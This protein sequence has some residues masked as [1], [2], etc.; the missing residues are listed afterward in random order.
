VRAAAFGVQPDFMD[1]WNHPQRANPDTV[2]ALEALLGPA[3]A[4][5]SEA[6]RGPVATCHLPEQERLW[7]WAAQLYAVRSRRSWGS[8]DLDDLARLAR[9]S[10][11][12]GAG[13]IQLNPL[14]AAAPVG[15]Q[16]ASPYFPSS[17]LFR[18]PAYIS[19]PHVR[20]YRAAAP[21]LTAELAEAAH[22]N[23]RGLIDHDR[24]HQVKLRALER[25]WAAG[26]PLRGFDAWAR[27]CGPGLWTYADYCVLA[28]RHGADWRTWPPPLRRPNPD[29]LRDPARARF[30]AWVQWLLDL[31]LGRAAQQ[32]RPICDLAIGA[33]P[34]GAD[35]WIWADQFLPGFTVGAPPDELNRDGQNWG[36]P[37]FS[38]SKLL[39]GGFGPFREIVRA[40]LRHA[41]GLRIDHVM[42]LF[43]LWLIP[44]GGGAGDGAYVTYPAAPML[45]II[46]SESRAAQALVI[47][48]DLG[49]VQPAVRRE[50]QRRHVLSY[51]LMF[52]EDGPPG[53]YSALS[54]AAVG[55]H[56]LPTIAGVW[57]GADAA[58]M[59][60]A[61]LVPNEGADSAMVGRL[62]RFGSVPPGASPAEA[63]LGAYSA[64]A[65]SPSRLL[66]ATL[67]D[68]LVAPRRPNIPGTTDEWPNWRI[69]L[70]GGLEGLRRSPRARALA[71]VMR[72]ARVVDGS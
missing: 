35:A 12:M 21:Q 38:P 41:L 44:D 25:I 10:R 14:H 22:L 24:V 33:D 30:H 29:I 65:A 60:G 23:T 28:E 19:I 11:R 39:D 51:R 26:P 70:P 13:F 4:M 9:W 2:T 71:E 66:A 42:G 31:Q 45:D 56:D 47:G 67:E 27:D 15:P 61:G 18:N 20:G 7:G 8:G 64:L 16:Q 17:R 68:A 69:A 62:S 52:F 55:T 40:N 72:G 49:T 48:E 37:A 32:L 50:L 3:P 34:G 43:R 46:A 59:R 58:A 54:L 63:V 5:A 6:T 36:F 53:G 57:T 1:A